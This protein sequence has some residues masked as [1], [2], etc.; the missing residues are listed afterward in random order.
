MAEGDRIE[1][2][3][4]HCYQSGE[5]VLFAPDV[6]RFGDEGYPVLVEGGVANASTGLLVGTV[7]NCPAGAITLISGENGK[8]RR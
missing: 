7:E 6:Y 1:L 4:D 3:Y 2:D 5:C 8:D